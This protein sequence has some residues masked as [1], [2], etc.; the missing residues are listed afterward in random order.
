MRRAIL[1][2]SERVTYGMHDAVVFWKI[3]DVIDFEWLLA[4]DSQVDDAALRARDAE[5]SAKI[6]PSGL[7][8]A[9]KDR[10]DLFRAWLDARRS[11]FPRRRPANTF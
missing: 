2:C 5:L 1:L 8:P 9:L 10:R 3:S 6:S 7:Q 4:D 11:H